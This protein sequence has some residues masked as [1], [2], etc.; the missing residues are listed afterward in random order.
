MKFAVALLLALSFCAHT[1]F[2]DDVVESRRL[3]Q[4]ALAAEKEKDAAGVVKNLRAASDL[5]PQHGTLLVQLA[6]ALEAVGERA[7]AV[8]I[9]ERVAAMGFVYPIEK[10]FP[11]KAYAAV[12]QRFALNAKPAGKA[13][14][15][16]TIDRLG[17]IPEGMAWDGKRLFVSSVRTKTIFAIAGDGTVTP[18]A[19]APWGVFGMAADPRRGVLWAVTA[20]LPQVEGF[21]AA[22][23]GRS[24]LLRIDLKDGHIVESLSAPEG[25][26]HFGDV[27]VA[28]DGAVYV[29]DSA[30]PVIYRLPEDGVTPRTLVPFL[31]GP[32]LSMQGLAVSGE[33]LYVADY[34]KGLFAVDRRTLDVHALGVPATASLLGVDGLYAVDE[35]TLVGT[36]NGT[37]PNRIIRI[38]L[39]PGGLAVAAV[40]T[41]LANVSG[42]GDPTLGV[43]AG[44]RFF[45][46][47]N[48]QWDLFDED[49]KILDPL[50]LSEAVVFSV[51][52]R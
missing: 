48:A 47:G 18:F 30:S 37:S 46:N 42:F 35:R 11:D 26:H 16:H 33:K 6:G 3:Y 45:F 51:P 29:S 43:I 44:N 52:L 13:R 41:L 12:A 39:A 14:R 1:L 10:E 25:E 17:L 7:E 2:A 20:A 4:A 36:Q 21:V 5:R 40:E 27:T 49:G 28:P 34:A 19:T 50:K 31:N 23:K 24:A 38:R 8:R 32:F 22:D 15:E 9:L